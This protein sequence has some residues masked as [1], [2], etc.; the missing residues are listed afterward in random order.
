[1][2]VLSDDSLNKTSNLKSMRIIKINILNLWEKLF[3]DGHAV[4]LA[5]DDFEGIPD[6]TWYQAHFSIDSSKKFQ[7]VFNCAARFRNVN[8]NDFQLHGPKMANSLN[9]VLLEFRLYLHAIV[10]DIKTMY[11]QCLVK[12]SY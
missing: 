10:S 8:L 3:K 1:M 6:K 7:V 5:D 11:Y 4:E 2:L 12:E 9:G